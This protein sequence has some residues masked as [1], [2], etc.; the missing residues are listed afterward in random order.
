MW[1]KNWIE[2]GDG[3]RCA[4]ARWTTDASVTMEGNIES[5]FITSCT[6]LVLTMFLAGCIATLEQPDPQLVKEIIGVVDEQPVDVLALSEE[7]KGFIDEHVDRKALTRYRLEQL[8][9]ILFAPD[10]FAIEYES[11]VTKTANE[12]FETH[13][14]NCLSMTNLFIAM[15]RYADIDAR[16]HLVDTQPEWD[17]SGNTLLWTQHINSTGFLRNGDRY[18][19]DFI[20]GRRT[21]VEDIKTISDEYALAIY[22]NNLGAEAI[23]AKDYEQALRDLRMALKLA[24]NLADGWNNMGA[25]Q[26]RLG[27]TDLARESFLQAIVLDG[28]NRTAISNLAR[29]YTEAGELKLAEQ[30][31]NRVKRH[32]QKNPYYHFADAMEY[33]ADQNYSKARERLNEAIRLKSDEPRFFDVLARVY[34]ALGDEQKRITSQRLAYLIRKQEVDGGRSLEIYS[35]GNV[36]L[37]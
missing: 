31:R 1:K 34:D 27:R 11:G 19:L 25:A 14:G 9:E 13:A 17:A 22:Y 35:S 36:V 26:R 2:R 6:V 7:L 5:R 29:M 15:A 33:L 12:T 4:F 18:V 32:R 24:P 23:I 37:K 21:P 8:R 30:Y 16:Y 28:Y 3:N 20:P 10:L